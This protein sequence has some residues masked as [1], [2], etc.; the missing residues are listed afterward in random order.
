MGLL[1][2]CVQ[3]PRSGFFCPR[4]ALQTAAAFTFP[5]T[6]ARAGERPAP[7]DGLTRPFLLPESRHRARGDV[8]RVTT[9]Q[10]KEG[11]CPC[12]GGTTV[13][14]RRARSR[15]EQPSRRRATV[16]TSVSP[17]AALAPTRSCLASHRGRSKVGFARSKGD[18]AFSSHRDSRQ[19]GS[20]TSPEGEAQRFVFHALSSK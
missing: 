11:G 12:P 5:G 8:R 1:F 20:A 15:E 19:D 3:S 6:P 17:R 18:G 10:G 2:G 4:P 9:V 14:L 13:T 16:T 7:T